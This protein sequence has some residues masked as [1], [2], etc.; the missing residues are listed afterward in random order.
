MILLKYSPKI[1]F[2]RIFSRSMLKSPAMITSLVEFA[3]LL[4]TGINSLKL[5]AQPYDQ[6][7]AK[8]V[9]YCTCTRYLM[10]T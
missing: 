6:P 4:R 9:H 7:K 10:C 8:Y 3:N 1:G 2:S 5:S